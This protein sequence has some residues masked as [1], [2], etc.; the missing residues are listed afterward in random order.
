MQTMRTKMQTTPA[1]DQTL[2]K[3]PDS[4]SKNAYDDNNIPEIDLPGSTNQASGSDRVPSVE[5]L[6]EST[7]PRKEA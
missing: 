1:A 7:R 2:P 4:S 3:M 5:P 6:P